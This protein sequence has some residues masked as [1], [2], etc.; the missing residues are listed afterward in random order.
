M[1]ESQ[2]AHPTSEFI[3]VA[4]NGGCVLLHFTSNLATVVKL[5]GRQ[6]S[7]QDLQIL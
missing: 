1:S 4:Y 7:R 5:A 2:K 6:V 3:I